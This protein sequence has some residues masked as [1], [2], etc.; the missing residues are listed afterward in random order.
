MYITLTSDSTV[1]SDIA[2]LSW[3]FNHIL[4]E[5]ISL[6][7]DFSNSLLSKIT[8]SISAS[9]SLESR[10]CLSYDLINWILVDNISRLAMTLDLLD[11]PTLSWISMRFFVF[12]LSD[13]QKFYYQLSV[14]WLMLLDLGLLDLSCLREATQLYWVSAPN[15]KILD[16]RF[17]VDKNTRLPLT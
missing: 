3:D 10:I 14:F 5:I 4:I 6:L 9:V 15:V 11:S 13:L 17:K 16:F 8:L 12:G 7:T 2:S 1:P